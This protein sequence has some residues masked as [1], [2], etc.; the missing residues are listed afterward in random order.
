MLKLLGLFILVCILGS[1][2]DGTIFRRHYTYGGYPVYESAD[3]PTGYA[4]RRRYYDTDT[5]TTYTA[6]TPVYMVA[7]APAYYYRQPRGTV[8]SG[9]STTEYGVYPRSY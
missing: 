3:S 9:A 2:A 4:V 6:A 7:A 8:Y 5:N 1:L